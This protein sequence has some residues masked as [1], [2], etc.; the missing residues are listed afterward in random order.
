MRS[1]SKDDPNRLNEGGDEEAGS[2]GTKKKDTEAVEVMSFAAAESGFRKTG[3]LGAQV[4]SIDSNH[5][6]MI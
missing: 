4:A 3:G 5:G 6:L 1:T 2:H